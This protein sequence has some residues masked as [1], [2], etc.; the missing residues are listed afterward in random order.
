MTKSTELEVS[1]TGKEYEVSKK[2]D[3]SNSDDQYVEWENPLISSE[4]EEFGKWIADY[5]SSVIDYSLEWRGDPRVDANDTFYLEKKDGSTI[6]IQAYENE[7]EFNGRFSG[8]M[9]ARQVVS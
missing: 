9:K 7:L 3:V 4:S 6:L 2:T 5:Y 8:R 1:V